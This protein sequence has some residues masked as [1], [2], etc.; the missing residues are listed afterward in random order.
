MSVKKKKGAQVYSIKKEQ[1]RAAAIF[2]TPLLIT[3]ILLFLLPNSCNHNEL[4]KLDH[5][6][7][8]SLL[9]GIS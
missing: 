7:D 1:H 6:F 9:C 8:R 4:Y 5:D 2:V 3:L